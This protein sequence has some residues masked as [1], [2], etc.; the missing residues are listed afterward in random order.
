MHES[1]DRKPEQNLW[2]YWPKEYINK[3]ASVDNKDNELSSEEKNSKWSAEE[4][5][6]YRQLETDSEHSG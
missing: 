6:Q 3:A 4:E 1:S 5:E 2:Y